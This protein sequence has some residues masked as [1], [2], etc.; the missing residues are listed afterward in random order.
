[1]TLGLTEAQRELVGHAMRTRWVQG[2]GRRDDRAGD[3]QSEPDSSVER[4]KTAGDLRARTAARLTLGRG[5]SS[6]S[7]SAWMTASR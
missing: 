2:E 1:M 4:A 3:G 7:V 5:R 6:T